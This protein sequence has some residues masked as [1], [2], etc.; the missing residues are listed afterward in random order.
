[1]NS[2]NLIQKHEGKGVGEITGGADDLVS[3]SIA[4]KT[5]VPADRKRISPLKAAAVAVALKVH[6]SA[7]CSF[8]STAVLSR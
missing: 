8:C 5:G 3:K 1:M 2:K 7:A 4:G 6:F